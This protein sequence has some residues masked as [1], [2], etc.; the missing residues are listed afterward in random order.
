ML[1]NADSSHIYI[2]CI[3]YAQILHEPIILKD[4]I[5]LFDLYNKIHI[6]VL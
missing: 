5:Q 1:R 2:G 6:F 4:Y 3:M